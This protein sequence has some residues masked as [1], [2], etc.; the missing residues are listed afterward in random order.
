MTFV[1]FKNECRFAEG[2]EKVFGMT[3]LCK[4]H[5]LWNSLVSKTNVGSYRVQNTF[6]NDE[7]MYD[8]R[9]VKFV[10]SKKSVKVR[11]MF[12]KGFG[13][14]NLRMIQML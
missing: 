13:M 14:M 3:H 2:S 1:N 4:I 5:V 10:I 9:A 12:R 7:F 6:R 8:S 11:I